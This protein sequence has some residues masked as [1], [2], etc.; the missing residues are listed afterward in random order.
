[1][2][3]GASAATCT[4]T[5]APSGEDLCRDCEEVYYTCGNCKDIF[6]IMRE[7]EDGDAW[8]DEP[9]KF[10]PTCGAAVG[11]VVPFS[12]DIGGGSHGRD[13]EGA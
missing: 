4:I 12:Y 9:P 5:Q 6:L 11:L 7:N 13:E 1:M 10:C 2:R 8:C 3:N